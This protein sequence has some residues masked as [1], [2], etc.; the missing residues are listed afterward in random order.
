MG[1]SRHSPILKVVSAATINYRHWHFTVF[2][3][4]FLMQLDKRMN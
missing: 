4:H 3:E 1:D 2:W